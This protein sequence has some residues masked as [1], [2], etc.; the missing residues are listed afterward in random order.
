VK[1]RK[2]PANKKPSTGARMK[3]RDAGC[4][5]VFSVPRHQMYAAGSVK[6]PTCGSLCDQVGGSMPR[7]TTRQPWG[8]W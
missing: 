5:K 7:N 3:C 6:C 4:K 1:K 8:N 2:K